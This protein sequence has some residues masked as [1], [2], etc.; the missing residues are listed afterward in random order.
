MYRDAMEKWDRENPGNS[1]LEIFTL[2]GASLL[3]TLSDK[4]SAIPI[5]EAARY[6]TEFRS[7]EPRLVTLRRYIQT[8]ILAL[9][10]TRI[11]LTEVG[12]VFIDKFLMDMEEFGKKY[13]A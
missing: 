1:Q 3:V 2:H 4:G 9:N 12:Q 13:P 8:G 6:L 11:Q 10:E 7:P 5:S